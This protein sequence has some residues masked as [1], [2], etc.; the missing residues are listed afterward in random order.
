VIS[1]GGRKLF[2]GGDTMWHGHWWSIAE[3]YGPFDA[4]FLPMNGAINRARKAA[5]DVPSTL[6][7]EQAVAAAEV[8]RAG[9]LVPIHYG[10]NSAVYVEHPDA[11]AA[12]RRICRERNRPVQFV[13]EGA[14]IVWP[15]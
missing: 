10:V 3:Q 5:V 1:G 7:P 12:V 2:H 4:A 14:S 15:E 8:L 9:V 13:A 11:V 6:T